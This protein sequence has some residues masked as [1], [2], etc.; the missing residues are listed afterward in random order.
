VLPPSAVRRE[1]AEGELVT[2]PIIDPV[3]ARRLFVIYSGERSLSEPERDLVN[4]LRL[5]LADT[6]DLAPQDNRK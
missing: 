5:R 3:V 6:K 1:L 4:T 2:H